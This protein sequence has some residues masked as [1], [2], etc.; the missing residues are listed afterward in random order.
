MNTDTLKKANE[1]N[2][3]ITRLN[4][5]IRDLSNK[6]PSDWCVESFKLSCSLIR[7]DLLELLKKKVSEIEKELEAL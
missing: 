3:W 2:T 1:L 5:T 6:C 4:R 7:A